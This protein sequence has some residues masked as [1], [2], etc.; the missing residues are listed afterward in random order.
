MKYKYTNSS[1]LD[2]NFR[3]QYCSDDGNF[4]V[5]PLAGKKVRYSIILKGTPTG[6]IYRK[7][8]TAMKD[9]VKLQKRQKRK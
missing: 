9:V 5:I 8:D 3:D 6:K 2:P 7:F 1:V 4:V